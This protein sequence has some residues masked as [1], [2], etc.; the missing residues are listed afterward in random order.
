MLLEKVNTPADIRRFNTVQLRQL[1]AEIRQYMVECCAKN[2]GHLGSSL[3]AVELIVALHAVFNTPK[4]KIVFDVGH[5]A[6][7]H[8]ILTG[9]REAFRKNRTRDGISGFPKRSESPYDAFGAGHSSTA[10]SAALGFAEAARLQGTGE[11]AVALL[12]DG[13]LTGGLA[14]E[15]LNNAGSSKADLLVI[16]N[17]NNMSIDQAT[18]GMHDYLLRVTTSHM[19]NKVKRKIWNKLGD[20]KLRDWVQRRVT[21]TKSNLV[22]GSG[23]AVFES[24]GFRYFGPIDGNDIAQVT[25]VLRRLRDLKGPRI[26]HVITRKGKGYAPAEADPTTW[27]APG[28]FDPAT[29]TRVKSARPADRYQD[30]FGEVLVDLARRDPRV[31]GVTPAMATGCGMHLMEQAFPDRFFDVGIEEEHAVTF[32]AGLAAAGM[33]PFCNIYSSFSQR[34]YDQIVHD[35]ALQDLPVVLCFDRAGLVGEDGATHHGCF[36]LA[37]YRSIPGTLIASPRNELELKNLLYTGLSVKGGPFIIRYPRGCG[38]GVAWKDAPY[39]ALTLGKGEKLLDG[40]KVAILGLGPVV[41][42]ALEAALRHKTDYWAAP[43]VYDL[44]FLKPLDTAI[45]EE[46]SRFEVILTVEEGTLKGGLY[47][48]VCEYFAGRTDAPLIKGLGIPDRFIAQDT[49]AAQR[50]ECCLDAGSIFEI[51]IEMMKKS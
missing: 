7:A 44:R 26:L 9:R 24:L 21:D 6:Y 11:R 49:Q 45:L 39:T 16:L 23:G 5:Q 28:R 48:A 1:C 51:L 43:A 15:G 47:G 31:V 3:G 2:P 33:K 46:A 30:V 10:I 25:D 20:G 34:A 8:K 41:N 37:A 18:G 13:A 29:G 17:D 4:D 32:S 27:H 35:V 38:E 42:R 40:K 36:D 14:W 12:G 19:Y 50:A 22:R